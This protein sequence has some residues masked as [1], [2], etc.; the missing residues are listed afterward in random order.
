MRIT[1]A[2]V[3]IEL[4]S[5]EF[6]IVSLLLGKWPETI[7]R[8]TLFQ[9]IWESEFVESNTINVNISRIREKL[10]KYNGANYI[11]TVRGIGYRWGVPVK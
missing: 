11:E 7:K 6:K 5:I 3:H 2:G 10:G 8:E 4:T 1:K 9:Q